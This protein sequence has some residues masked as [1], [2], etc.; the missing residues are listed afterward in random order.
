MGLCNK[1][2]HAFTFRGVRS[3]LCPPPLPGPCQIINPANRIYV[4]NLPYNCD[5]AALRSVFGGFG[6]ILA[7]DIP[8]DVMYV[9]HT[10]TAAHAG[11][12][13]ACLFSGNLAACR[14]P[15]GWFGVLDGG[16]GKDR[17]RGW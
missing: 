3:C 16:M 2:A 15:P 9:T 10:F 6:S 7:V 14:D 8:I 5:D 17:R 12:C 11:Y 1:L 13:S 4:G